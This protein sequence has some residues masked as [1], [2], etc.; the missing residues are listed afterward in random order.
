MKSLEEILFYIEQQRKTQ[1][2]LPKQEQILRC[3]SYFEPQQTKVII[4]SQDPYPNKEDACGLAFSVEHNKTPPS[5]KNIFKELVSDIGCLIPSNGNLEPWAKQGVLLLNSIL[6]T[7]EGKS[8]SHKDIGWQDYTTSIIQKVVDC[9]HPFVIIAWGKYAESKISGL[10][11]H[12]KVL[13][14]RGKHPSPLSQPQNGFFNG[15]YFSKAN[16]W[17]IEHNIEPINWSL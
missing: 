16:K 1:N 2:I 7:E 4:I 8:L 9:K 11:L 5:L 14:L 6:T 17:L 10:N 12:S 3:L 13:I 15:N